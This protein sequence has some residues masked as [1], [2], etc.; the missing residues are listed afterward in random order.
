MLKSR[1][2]DSGAATP[3]AGNIQ[4]P[5]GERRLTSTNV[6]VGPPPTPGGNL[7]GSSSF[8]SSKSAAAPHDRPPWPA[9]EASVLYH[10]PPG[11][12]C[13]LNEKELADLCFPNQVRDALQ[14][15]TN[16]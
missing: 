2:Q 3:G 4:L 7:H 16:F 14:C 5:A 11:A 8:A 10:Y 15:L 13:P 9:Y 6:A 12:P 1:G